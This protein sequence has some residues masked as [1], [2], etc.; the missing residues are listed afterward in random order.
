MLAPG[1]GTFILSSITVPDTIVCAIAVVIKDKDIQR[2]RK[3]LNFI[4]IL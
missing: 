1:K 4:P 3:F 2:A